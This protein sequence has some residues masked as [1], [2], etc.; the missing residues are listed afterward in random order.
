MGREDPEGRIRQL[1]LPLPCPHD[2]SSSFERPPSC[3]VGG[4]EGAVDVSIE[5]PNI[6]FHSASKPYTVYTSIIAL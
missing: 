3:L 6:F 2:R 4:G 5:E 1:S